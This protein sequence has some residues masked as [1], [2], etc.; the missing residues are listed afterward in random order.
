[1]ATDAIRLSFG[2][3]PE[4]CETSARR[5]LTATASLSLRKE[6][7]DVDN[8][9]ASLKKSYPEKRTSNR[10]NKNTNP[11]NQASV[12]QFSKI[13][14]YL[15]MIRSLNSKIIDQMEKLTTENSELRRKI[16]QIPPPSYAAVVSKGSATGS[17]CSRSSPISRLPIRTVTPPPPQN[18]QPEII[19]KMTSKL[20]QLEQ[21]SLCNDLS[22]QGTNVDE[23]L[24]GLRPTDAPA[25]PNE[26]D[27][28]RQR[29]HLPAAA[30]REAVCNLLQ[31][32]VPH[33]STDQLPNI[34]VHGREKKHIKVTCLSRDVKI[35]V[36]TSFKRSKPSNLYVNEYL[37]KN[38]ASLLYR[39][40]NLKKNHNSICSVF[41]RNGL[42]CYKLH[43]SDQTFTIYSNFEI[44][45]LEERLLNGVSSE[46]VVSLSS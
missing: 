45:K 43:G 22:L 9:L 46:P 1:M 11:P 19:V 10:L 30:L 41:S 3:S 23:M 44:N 14:E 27:N 13:V 35:N 26:E 4:R 38:R 5:V 32:T 12:D 36:L 2:E 40:R 20:D 18:Y 28:G 8:L 39:L 31:P 16:D 15:D 7:R 21:N 25:E 24:A 29:R 34:T 6:L 37:T 42:I 33:I 17:V